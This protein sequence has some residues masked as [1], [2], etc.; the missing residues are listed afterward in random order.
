MIY[1]LIVILPFTA[2]SI[3]TLMGEDVLL[4][5]FATIIIFGV[6]LGHVAIFSKDRY[7]VFVDSSLKRFILFLLF[8]FF[9]NLG[10]FGKLAKYYTQTV[11]LVII[12]LAY[13]TF[14]NIFNKFSLLRMKKI[15]EFFMIVS[16]ILSLFSIYQYFAA[17]Y[18]LPAFDYFRNSNMYYVARE[19]RAASGWIGESRVFG[20]AP[21]PSFWAAFLLIPISILLPK[22]LQF[23]V[24]FKTLLFFLLL[25]LSF[26]LAFSRSGWLTYGL[27]FA[28]YLLTCKRRLSIHPGW[29]VLLSLLMAVSSGLV[30]FLLPNLTGLSYYMKIAGSLTAMRMVIANP[31]FG[32]GWGAFQHNFLNYQLLPGFAEHWA[33]QMQFNAGFAS[34]IYLR[35]MAEAGSIGLILFMGIIV[36][37]YKKVIYL[38]S[39]KESGP[40]D[41]LLYQGLL[42]AFYS[43]LVTWFYS[44]AYNLIYIWF[45]LAVIAILPSCLAREE[46]KS[47]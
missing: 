46:E 21:E 11:N 31:L 13:F 26:F 2:L 23:K 19:W 14:L 27:V 37:I 17:K 40:E 45:I 1:W 24:P 43:I 29:L 25:N 47:E 8:I 44:E 20:V 6:L 33:N 7:R 41:A 32:V 12:F 5:Y 28:L 4:T 36:S 35:I 39:V 10:G 18:G 34:N 16:V 15:V 22:I 42:L 38:I 9:A 30:Y 3:F